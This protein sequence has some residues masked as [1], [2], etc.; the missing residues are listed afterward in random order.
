VTPSSRAEKSA[1]GKAPRFALDAPTLR[2]R[3][4]ARV[5]LEGKE[6][7]AAEALDK[8][9]PDES[10]ELEDGT[11]VS[12]RELL[13]SVNAGEQEASKKGSSLLNLKSVG[14]ALG[15]TLG[16]AQSQRRQFLQEAGLN[17]IP[18]APQS[19]P[20]PCAAATCQ[21]ATKEH[22]ARWQ[23]QRGDQDTVAVYT[24][25]EAVERTPNRESASCGVNWD[26][27]VYLMG[28]AFSVLRF[29]TDAQAKRASVGQAHARAALY[30]LG[31]ATPVWQKEAAFPRTTVERSFRTPTAAVSVPFIPLVRAEGKVD[32]GATMSLD[33]AAGGSLDDGGA[34]L[35]CSSLAVPTLAVTVNPE[36]TLAVGV[37]R[38]INLAKGGVRAE[39]TVARA[40]IPTHISLLMRPDARVQ[41]LD[42]QSD[43]DL[44][45]MQ[46]RI[47]AWFKIKDICRWGVCLL[48]DIL[49]IPTKGE[50]N[51]WE[52]A[53]GFPYKSTLM[54][55][56][57]PQL[58]VP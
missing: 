23:K 52:D 2:A 12:V 48:G 13:S 21:P 17:A 34:A 38:L 25:F 27:G 16:K 54:S 7:S 55:V 57:G 41:L 42:F 8:F 19:T 20:A 28:K 1:N 9:D 31:Q 46:G 10:T 50:V 22:V 43:L 36:V 14:W 32:G 58:F 35:R 37:K 39:L 26:S 44:T 6:M 15:G 30:V 5:K 29:A 51:L 47:Y 40:R 11:K 24:Q 3:L 45:L 53:D 49:G 56:H 18:I 33:T 4:T